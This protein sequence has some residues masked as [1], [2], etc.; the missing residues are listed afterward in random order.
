MRNPK[1]V[2]SSSVTPNPTNYCAKGVLIG[3][4]RWQE[5]ERERERSGFHVS[6]SLRIKSLWGRQIGFD[7]GNSSFK[8]N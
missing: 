2:S 6:G 1:F 8:L 5:R 7:W 4:E 3:F